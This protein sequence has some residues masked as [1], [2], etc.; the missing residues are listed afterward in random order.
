MGARG[1]CDRARRFARRR[2]LARLPVP[3][4]CARD[5]RPSSLHRMGGGA[6]VVQRQDRHE[7]HFVLREQPVARGGDAAAAPRRDLRLGGLER[8]LPRRQ[9]PRRHHLHLPQA[10]AGHAG[11][12]RAA[13]P[14]RARRQEPSH[15]RA[16][17]RTGNAV[18]KRTG[19]ESGRHVGR[20]SVA[21]DGRAVLPRAQRRS[22]EGC[23][24]AAFRRQ[25]GRAGPA[26]A[27]Q[28][29]GLCPFFV[30]G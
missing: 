20:A 1:L 22:R 29:R 17:V 2:A 3:Q 12:D 10:L 23:G 27:R 30:Q 19:P 13:R 16:G 24:T 21:R 5:A 28:L 14:G 26:H 8:R 9:P 7:R 11:E 6:E 25:L 18:G 15:G 4:Q